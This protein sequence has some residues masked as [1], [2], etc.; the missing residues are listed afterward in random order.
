[1]TTASGE[2]AMLRAKLIARHS[3]ESKIHM[4]PGARPFQCKCHYKEACHLLLSPESPSGRR[5]VRPLR[6]NAIA[7]HFLTVSKISCPKHRSCQLNRSS[8][9]PLPPESVRSRSQGHVK[10]LM[11]EEANIAIKYTSRTQYGCSILG[12]PEVA[13]A[14]QL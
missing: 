3:C 5:R 4:L 7:F 11:S 8:R 10:D 14:I 9:L 2:R 1:M 13:V 6:D 12:L